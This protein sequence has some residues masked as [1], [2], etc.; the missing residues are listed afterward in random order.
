MLVNTK[1]DGDDVGPDEGFR[2][3]SGFLIHEA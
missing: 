3:L 2:V 1:D